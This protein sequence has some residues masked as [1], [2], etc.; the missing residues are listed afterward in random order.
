MKGTD[1]SPPRVALV[2]DWLVGWGGAEQ[3]LA[4]LAALY[5]QAPL[6]TSVWA[7]DPRVAAAFEGREI[8][9]TWLQQLP[10]AGRHY[11]SLFPFMGRAFRGLDLSGFDL[12]ISSSHALSKAVRVHGGATHLCYCHAPPRYLWDL[13]HQYSP[14]WKG[15]VRAPVARRLRQVD[16][17]AA[18]GV[19]RFVANSRTVAD[20]IRKHYDREAEV[21]HPPV[22]VERFAAAREPGDRSERYLAGGRMVPYKGLDIAIAAANQAQLP[23][24]VFGDG[25]ERGRLERLGGPTVRFLGK[26]PDEALPGL[27]ARSRAYLFPVEEDFGILPVEAMAAGT[28]VLA[29]ARGGATETVGRLGGGVLIS[30]RDPDAWARSMVELAPRDPVP[31]EALQAFAPDRFRAEWRALVGSRARAA[32][33]AGA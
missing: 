3:V 33:G 16:R 28:P 30:S 27:L 32:M 17:E 20:R 11:R 1:R 22:H 9:T 18:R 7:P 23:L 19:T 8:R 10:G 15:I 26:V 6:Y 29:L 13:Y 24:D 14:G 25:P 4:E 2:H 21:L 5:P 12:V 31:L